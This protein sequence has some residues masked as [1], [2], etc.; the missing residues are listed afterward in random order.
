MWTYDDEEGVIYPHED[1]LVIKAT[2]AGKGFQRILVYT[3]SSVDILFKSTLDEMGIVYLKL[4]RTNTSLKGF[5]GGWL[6][7]QELL[8][9][10]LLV[11]PFSLKNAEATYQ[12]LVNRIFKPL[13]GHT[14]EV[15][16]D[17]MIMKSKN[18]TDHVRHLKETF[19]L[20]RKYRMK[21]NPEKCAFGI[22][23]GKFLGFLWATSSVLV[24]KDEGKQHPM[25]Y[26]SKVLVDEEI[27]YPVLEKWALALV[28]TARKLRPYFQAHPIV[29]MTDQT[30]RQM[31][32][33]SYASGRLVK[34]FVQL[35]EF[36]LTY[37]PRGAVQAQAL[38]NFVLDCTEPSEEVHEEQPVEQEKPEG[39]W[40]IMVDGSR[41]EQG[42]VAGVVIRSAEGVE[43]FYAVKFEFQLTNNQAE[44]EA[45][46][47]GLKLAHAIRAERA[48]GEKMELYL[49]KEKQ[50]IRLFRDIEIK[51]IAR[52]ENYRADMLARMAAT[53]NPKLP[54][55]I[56][57]EVRTLPS[58]GEEIEVMGVDI[59]RERISP[60]ECYEPVPS[61]T[62]VIEHEPTRNG[63]RLEV[64]TNQMPVTQRE[65]TISRTHDC[66]D[67]LQTVRE[68]M[69]PQVYPRSVVEDSSRLGKKRKNDLDL[70]SSGNC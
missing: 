34:W 4:E 7:P 46:I 45:F 23:S 62:S 2:V 63:H 43:V 8:S 24:K 1:A 41:S 36:N 59:E 11:M 66:F 32:L 65:N 67:M 70:M 13:I 28:T 69:M 3:G 37:R 9:R 35:S 52:T 16:V 10:R 48:R 44:Y 17:D 12:R 57:L 42:S 56:P 68:N 58:I 49:K 18:S 39:V 47:T 26:T 64:H 40:L 25:Y 31:L 22:S 14:M 19:D 53:A 27:R 38:A 15:Y 20:L 33:K 29:V 21:L 6:S 54:K 51:Q 30:L 61:S 60:A 5:R 50:M 55:S